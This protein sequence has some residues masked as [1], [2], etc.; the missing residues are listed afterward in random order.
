MTQPKHEERA[1]SILGA[2]GS[3]RWLACPGCPNLCKKF[4]KK[5]G[6]FAANEGTAAHELGELCYVEGCEAKKYLGKDINVAGDTFTVT[7]DMVAAVQVYLDELNSLPGEGKV[8]VRFNMEWLHKG[9]FGTNDFYSYDEKTRTL[10]VRDY[11]HGK[12]VVVDAV[13]NEQLLYYAL[14]ACQDVRTKAGRKTVDIC[15]IDV[16]IVQPRAFH[17]DGP[18]RSHK[19]SIEEL[20]HWGVT[21]LRAGAK[22]TEDENAPLHAGDHC[23]FCD[24]Y[25]GCPEVAKRNA[26]IAKA[27][28]ETLVL[29]EPKDMSPEQMAKLIEAGEMLSTWYK[30][31]QEFA[32][33]QAEKG[34]RIAGHK[35]VVSK[36]NRAWKDK[37]AAKALILEELGAKNAF[38]EPKLLGLSKVESVLGKKVFA[39]KFSSLIHRPEKNLLVPE[40]DKRP[41]VISSPEDDFLEL[42]DW[43]Q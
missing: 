28:F 34:V 9:M 2:S 5:A 14:G 13:W 43:M 36:G 38:E 11:K 1:H 29:P 31:V 7:H 16:G 32:Q 24:A 26:M 21:V 3:K 12:G 30:A 10:Y 33:A 35:L 15:N 23:R 27:D 39:E 8:E 4:P 6:G 41:E 40:S 17:V 37:A 22:A 19:L 25:G 20:N 42:E 18:V